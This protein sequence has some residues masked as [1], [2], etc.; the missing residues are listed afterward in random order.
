MIYL[1]FNICPE[2]EKIFQMITQTDVSLLGRFTSRRFTPFLYQN[3]SDS[4]DIQ[5][6][7]LNLIQEG[8]DGPVV[9]HLYLGPKSRANFDPRASI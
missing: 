9:A 4:C 7:A 2:C 1:L 3:Y 5:N 6:Y 8:H